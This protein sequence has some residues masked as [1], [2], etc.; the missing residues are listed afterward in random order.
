MYLAVQEMG[1]T[2][3]VMVCVTQLHMSAHATLA[4]QGM[5]VNYLT[6]QVSP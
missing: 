6:V 5:A 1:K 2:A 4:G 3:P